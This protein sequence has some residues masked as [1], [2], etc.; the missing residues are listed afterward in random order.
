MDRWGHGN[1]NAR[2]SR[3]DTHNELAPVDGTRFGGDSALGGGASGGG[4]LSRG[5]HEGDRG[6]GVRVQPLLSAAEPRRRGCP[7]VVLIGVRGLAGMH[8][9]GTL[10]V[11][12]EIAFGRGTQKISGA[13]GG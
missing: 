4:A 8:S 9:K 1:G 12:S 5:V 13:L 10:G 6:A 7:L 2:V 11:L 3:C